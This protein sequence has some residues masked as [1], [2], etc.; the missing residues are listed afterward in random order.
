MNI[1]PEV[2]VLMPVYNGAKYLRPAI[3]SILNQTYKDF[4]FL[5]INDGSTDES[6][7]I[8]LSYSDDR[9]RYVKNESNLRLI[10]TLN[11]GISLAKGKYIA[12]MDCDDI[13][14]PN[15]F[16]EQIQV[17][18]NNSTLD[19]V[20]GRSYDLYNDLSIRKNLR[21]LPLHKDAFRFTSLFEVSFIHPCL[22]IKTEVLRKEPFMDNEAALNVEDFELGSR[23]VQKGYNIENLN[24][25][26]IYYRKNLEG[27]CFTHREE[28]KIKSFII[29]KNNLAA[30]FNFKLT[31]SFYNLLTEKKG[32]DS[33]RKLRI[34]SSN[35]KLLVNSFLEKNKKI[36]SRSKSDIK[37][38][39]RI[40]KFS[41][42]VSALKEIPFPAKIVVLYYFMSNI[43]YCVDKRFVEAIKIWFLDWSPM[44]KKK[45]L[46]ND[47]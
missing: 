34:A 29:A 40:R 8:I 46:N 45:Y 12:R 21:F 42:Y 32:F 44:S 4:E 2:T 22:M 13:S 11:K 43:G 26:Q 3:E 31:E 20:C 35:L 15:R 23:L 41:F 5:I 16:E 47:K 1:M 24:S 27:V 39:M 37:S 19:G 7:R 14:F 25:F 6:E 18:K 9:I 38:W 30:N 33:L 17:L 36:D 10:K 28:Q